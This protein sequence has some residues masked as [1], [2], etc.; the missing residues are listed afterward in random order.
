MTVSGQVVDAATGERMPF[1]VITWEQ[2]NTLRGLSTN[3]SGVYAFNRKFSESE[4]ELTCS[5][6]GYKKEHIRL[7]LEQ[8]TRFDDV[9]CRLEPDRIDVNQLVVV[10]TGSYDNI[11]PQSASVIDIG[12][13]SPMGEISTISA[14]QSLPSV[15]VAPMLSKGMNV[16]GSPP[17]GFRVLVDDITVYNQSHLF[18]LIDS[19]NGDV[20]QRSGFYYD[21]AP[22]R[23]Q[24]QPGGILSLVTKTG[25]LDKFS[26]SAGLSNSSVRLTMNGP[27]KK[28][29]S[30]WL[31]SGRKSYMNT[32][33]WFHNA[34]L[35]RWGLNVRRP[36]SKP[37]PGLVDLESYLVRK[38][39]TDADFYDI[40]GKLY[41]EGKGGRRLILSGYFGGDEADYSAERLFRQISL[42]NP[43]GF[44][45]RPVFTHNDWRNGSA[46][47]KYTGWMGDAVYSSTVAGLSI[48][49]T[50]YEQEDFMYI[51]TQGAGQSLNAFI[52][53]FQNKSVLNDFSFQQAFDIT[54]SENW[55]WSTG[56]TFNYYLG[57]YAES[58]FNRPGYLSSI[59]SGQMDFFAQSDFT[60]WRNLSVFAGLR[61]HF[62][63]NGEYLRFSPRFKFKV[64]PDRIFSFG[65]GFSRSHQFI[66][67]ISFSNTT[68]NDVWVLADKNQKPSSVNNFTAG[69]YLNT[70]PE[71]YAQLEGYVKDFAHLR[72]HEINAFSLTGTFSENPWFA[73][74]KGRAKGIE[75]L[76]KS[77][78]GSFE[79]TQSAALSQVLLSN[80]L[81]NNGE[82]FH[83]DWDRTFDYMAGL[84]VQAL[85][86]LSFYIA[87]N[88]AT[89]NPN[90]LATFGDRSSGPNRLGHYQRTDFSAEYKKDF[91]SYNLTLSASVFNLFNTESAWYRDMSITLDQNT[92]P[93]KIV[94]T[95]VDVYDMGMQPSFNIRVGF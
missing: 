73:D 30:S 88:F 29:S 10:G 49:T 83:A 51:K 12:N 6:T 60:G 54:A 58:S 40:H 93:N 57:E 33:D 14:L 43:D 15:S 47:A 84:K 31:L 22:A 46:S 1:A 8:N 76:A 36:A 44:E 23:I 74:N 39:E 94:G 16:R 2:D 18:G 37:G 27:L 62:Y 7:N 61:T 95:P 70:G 50:K 13:F 77:E 17:D 79:L 78:L 85:K 91:G 65:G 28:G 75:L 4:I 80:P 19:F 21:V 71:F 90:K 82:A 87:W 72:L 32:V 20:L 69:A 81:I 24:S 41:F 59:T 48:Y 67:Q 53:P 63:T 64:F 68:S 34:D 86:D 3:E 55:F 66:N 56:F 35:T 42:N 45:F 89:G 26:G 52:F 92:I 11:N 9:T 38:G 25:S 5:F